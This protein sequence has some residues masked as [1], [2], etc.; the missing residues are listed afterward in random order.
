MGAEELVRGASQNCADLQN[1]QVAKLDALGESA[2]LIEVS[3]HV[4]VILID[5]GGNRMA[6]SVVQLIRLFQDRLQPGPR[7]IIIKCRALCRAASNYA[8]QFAQS[9]HTISDSD[10]FWKW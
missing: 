4:A 10:G 3:R 2:S 5:I 8:E 7:V 1:V 9:E 6:A